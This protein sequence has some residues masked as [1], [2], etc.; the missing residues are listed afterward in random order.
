MTGLTLRPM[1]EDEFAVYAERLT[2]EYA[3]AHRLAGNWTDEDALTRSRAELEEL[4]PDGLATAHMELFHAV[5]PDGALVGVV[6]LCLEAPGGR[7][8]AYLFDIELV[9]ELRGRGWGRELLALAEARVLEQGR[10]SLTL[11]VFGDNAVARRMYD[12]AGY[13]VVTQQMRKQL[14]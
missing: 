4:L 14:F 13:E 8:G 12:A 2:R 5:D 1:A 7:P 3:E 11:N 10:D 9:P 6:W